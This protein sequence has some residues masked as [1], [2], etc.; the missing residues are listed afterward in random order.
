MLLYWHSKI[1]AIL[2]GFNTLKITES[3]YSIEWKPL[4]IGYSK[5]LVNYFYLYLF[6]KMKKKQKI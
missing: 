1:I 5:Y 6:P 3:C 4:F 2:K